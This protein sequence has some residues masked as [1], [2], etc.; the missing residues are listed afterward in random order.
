MRLLAHTEDMYFYLADS[1]NW[2]SIEIYLAIF[3]GSAS[4]YRIF[5]RTYLPTLMG[6]TRG[7]NSNNNKASEDPSGGSTLRGGGVGGSS[8]SDRGHPYRGF[9]GRRSTTIT[10]GRGGAH[11]FRDANTD[12]ELG[13]NESEELIIQG[14]SPGKTEIHM[15]TE[16][17]MEVLDSKNVA[18]LADED[19]EGLDSRALGES[20]AVSDSRRYR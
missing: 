9:G 6:S 3:C 12:A 18:A 8:R 13:L 11:P 7:S 4:A 10:G 1:L 15:R 17:R 5:L 16:F 20:P 14:G 2:C 19:D